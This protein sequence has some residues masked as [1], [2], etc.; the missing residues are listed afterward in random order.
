MRT[1]LVLVLLTAC[2]QTQRTNPK[3]DEATI[4]ARLAQWVQ[5]YNAGDYAA[6]AT[7]WAPGLV[8]T[9]GGG[10][11]DI[12]YD[13]EQANAKRA[14]GAPSEQ[15]ELQID[16]VIVVADLAV[17]RDTWHAIGPN[18]K[19]TFRSQEVWERQTDGQWKISRW[20]DAPKDP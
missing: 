9:P 15:F 6:A 8:G 20:I 3:D 11:P 4:R 16:E 2:A 5:Q 7:I 12:T 14:S 1:F 18:T 19:A 17:V 13:R 10:F